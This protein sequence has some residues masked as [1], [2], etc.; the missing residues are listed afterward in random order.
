[1]ATAAEEVGHLLNTPAGLEQWLYLEERAAR[2]RLGEAGWWWWF[3][4]G[5]WST[6]ER[7]C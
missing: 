7:E 3:M 4:R 1:M 6:E 2:G 5:W